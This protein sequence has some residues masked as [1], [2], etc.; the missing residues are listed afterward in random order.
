MTDIGKEMILH[1]GL[2]KTA[3]TSFQAVMHK[4]RQDFVDAGIDP[5]QTRKCLVD[6]R[7]RHGDIAFS[8]IRNGVLDIEPGHV[9]YDFDQAKCFER[10]RTELVA[11]LDKSDSKRFLISTEALS[12]LRTQREI[13]AL[14]TLFADRIDKFRIVLV[15]RDK[16][17]WLQSYRNQII[18]GS[19]TPSSNPSSA[20]YLNG[21]NWLTDFDA[22]IDV[23]RRGFGE[24]QVLHYDKQD[25]VGALARHMGV[26]IGADTKAYRKN[27]RSAA[28]GLTR[29]PRLILRKVFGNKNQG[30]RKKI[31][32]IREGRKP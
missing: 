17:E 24:V 28:P 2:H 14:K 6:A 22:L 18:K 3:T 29:V 25:M 19:I 4:H 12:Y 26:S 20:F 30:L 7:A 21:D 11:Y 8:V 23:Y 31:R 1:I 32:E 13:E 5:Y 16:N 10:T 15:L 9:L 27:Q